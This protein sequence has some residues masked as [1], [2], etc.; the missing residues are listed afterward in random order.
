MVVELGT[1]KFFQNFAYCRPVYLMLLGLHVVYGTY[2]LD[3]WG[4]ETRGSAE[5]FAFWGSERWSPNFFFW[6]G[7]QTLQKMKF[8]G[9]NTEQETRACLNDKIHILVN[10]KLLSRIMTNYENPR[11]RRPPYWI[12]ENVNISRLDEGI[13]T[14]FGGKVQHAIRMWPLNQKTE[15][16]VNLRHVIKQAQK[17]FDL[18]DYYHHHYHQFIKN[19]CQTHVLT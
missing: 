2:D 18:M 14:K 16:E 1:P 17:S 3:Q 6:G 19:T 7:G 15:P 8:W 13:Y 12:L 4:L 10:W 11:W 5:A 9:M